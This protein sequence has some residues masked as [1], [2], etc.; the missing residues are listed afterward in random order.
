MYPEKTTDK[1][2]IPQWEYRRLRDIATR[3]DVLKSELEY[4]KKKHKDGGYDWELTVSTD[5]VERILGLYQEKEYTEI[6]TKDDL[7]EALDYTE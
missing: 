5:M 6:E 1:I 4:E 2:M 7:A 3:V